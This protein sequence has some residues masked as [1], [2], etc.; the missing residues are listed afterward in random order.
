MAKALQ[1]ETDLDFIDLS[2][3]DDNLSSQEEGIEVAI[4][5]PDNKPSG[6]LITVY[7]PDSTAAQRA[8]A[9]VTAEVEASLAA[10]AN[11]DVD[12]P[13]A[14]K[15]RQLAYL[16]KVTKGWNKPIGA[17]RL[18]FS[19]ENALAVYSKYPM[20]FDQVKFTAD[21]RGAFTKG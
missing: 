15:R 13:A 8:L 18:E 3:F 4:V 10:D 21:R 11:L 5:R 19:Q 2:V 16:A 6:L 12:S 1:Q 9:E 20:I 17:D 7:G 14:Q